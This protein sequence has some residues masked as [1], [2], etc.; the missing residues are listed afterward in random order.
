[1]I[2]R[3]EVKKKV[4]HNY[5]SCT[6]TTWQ[7]KYQTCEVFVIEGIPAASMLYS[8]KN[9]YDSPIVDEFHLNK[10]LLL[11]YDAGARMR[12]TLYQRYKN[13]NIRYAKNRNDFLNF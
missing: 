5:F 7:D 9:A 8:T 11:M 2:R 10:G 13:V 12:K 4:L 3:P 6:T 1:M